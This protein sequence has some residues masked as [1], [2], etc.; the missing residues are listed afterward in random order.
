LREKEGE[1][2]VLREASA[3]HPSPPR[4]KVAAR[5]KKGSATRAAIPLSINSINEIGST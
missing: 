3:K 4:E 1:A 5:N 2:A